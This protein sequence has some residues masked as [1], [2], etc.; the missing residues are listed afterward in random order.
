MPS[1]SPSSGVGTT[2][3]VSEIESLADGSIII[4][5]GTGAPTTLAGFTASNGTLKHESGGLEANVSAYAGFVHITGGATSAVAA[6]A[7][8]DLNTGTDATKPVTAD[9]LAGSNLGKRVFQ[10]KVFDD[11]TAA[12]TGDGKVIFMIP[13]ECNGM[14]LVDVEAYV[15]GASSSGALTIQ[16][17]NVTQAADMLSTAITIDQSETTSLTAATAPVIDAANDDVATGDLIAIDVDG[18]GTSA[19]GLGVVLSFQLP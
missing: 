15:T 11:A 9:A 4:G 6:A 10:I 3:E 8:A 2:V 14:N 7:A 12:T 5:D 13:V 16:V 1:Y 17:R 18:A 19:E